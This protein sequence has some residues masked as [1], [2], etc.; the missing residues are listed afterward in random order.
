MLFRS[1]TAQHRADA[2]G[3]SLGDDESKF[4][5][6]LKGADASDTSEDRLGW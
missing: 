1:C 4:A 5:E 6:K 3:T 2:V